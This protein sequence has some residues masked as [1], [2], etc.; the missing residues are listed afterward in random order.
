MQMQQTEVTVLHDNKLYNH[1]IWHIFNIERHI[2]QVLVHVQ[3]QCLYP[4]F[5]IAQRHKVYCNSFQ[6]GSSSI[7]SPKN[8]VRF[9]YSM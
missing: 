4:C 5:F 3:E 6:M 8:F 7:V 2:L 1:N 9:S